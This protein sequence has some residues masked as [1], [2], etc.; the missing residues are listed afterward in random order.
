MQWN[1]LQRTVSPWL[2]FASP[3]TNNSSMNLQDLEA[4]GRAVLVPVPGARLQLPTCM[5]AIYYHTPRGTSDS[6][7]DAGTGTYMHVGTST[8]Y[9]L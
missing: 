7:S 5:A 3:D 1:L 2:A 6:F 9:P 8:F 4:K